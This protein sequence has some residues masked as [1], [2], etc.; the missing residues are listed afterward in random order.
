MDGV[1]ASAHSNME[2]NAEIEEESFQKTGI[3]TGSGEN[4][5]ANA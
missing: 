4:R 2:K 3:D 5:R 1:R